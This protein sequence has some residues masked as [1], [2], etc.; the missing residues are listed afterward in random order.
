VVE[1]IT[2]ATPFLEGL[3]KQVRDG[4]DLAINSADGAL[5]DAFVSASAKVSEGTQ[6]AIAYI[7][8]HPVNIVGYGTYFL[9][10]INRVKTGS[11]SVASPLLGEAQV[12]FT[13]ASSNTKQDYN[14]S[15]QEVYDG[16]N[17]A[18]ESVIITDPDYS[19]K[20][21]QAATQ[22]EELITDA[23]TASN[24]MFSDYETQFL[25]LLKSANVQVNEANKNFAYDRPIIRFTGV[26]K[27]PSPVSFDA[28]NDFSFELENIG[29]KTWNCYV[30]L[31][32]FDQYRKSVTHDDPTGEP[33][34][35]PGGVRAYKVTVR[36]PKV[37]NGKNFGNKMYFKILPKTA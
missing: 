10:L 13:T 25:T 27:L 7:S 8:N 15:V 37:V 24:E 36:V 11:Q 34:L 30:G 31:Q 22:V 23:T 21:T 32:I 20:Y 3:V 35:V 33:P 9:S 19:A 5:S 12:L 17:N 2:D 26:A 16:F 14:T 1:T 18:I 29:K 28:D 6:L 4:L